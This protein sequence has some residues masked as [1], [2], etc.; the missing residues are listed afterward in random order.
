MFKRD[1]KTLKMA[2]FT[3]KGVQYHSTL[4]NANLKMDTQLHIDTSGMDKYTK[5]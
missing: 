4:G 1:F 3:G 5:S 2:E